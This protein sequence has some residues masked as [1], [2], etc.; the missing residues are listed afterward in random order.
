MKEST[1]GRRVANRESQCFGCVLR[2]THADIDNRDSY[3][4]IM[5]VIRDR[6]L[7]VQLRSD[8]A[9]PAEALEADHQRARPRKTVSARL[10]LTT[11]SSFSLPIRLPRR[12]FDTVVISSI[13]S[14]EALPKPLRSLGSTNI[15]SNGA[16]VGSVVKA[17]I[18][19]ELVASNRSSC[20]I[21]A[22]R[23]LPAYGPPAVTVQTSPRFIRR[24]LRTPRQ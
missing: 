21:T 17:Q 23:G 13:I 4:G 9:K 7:R 12:A 1:F 24:C 11:S 8:G 19:M 10:S 22:G 15:R 16:S 5:P 18:V 14:R 3:N 6:R 2:N 20:T